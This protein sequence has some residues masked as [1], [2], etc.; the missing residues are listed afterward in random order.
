[1]IPDTFLDSLS[2]GNAFSYLLWLIVGVMTIVFLVAFASLLY[3]WHYYGIGFFKRWLL[4]VI[5][6]GVGAALVV[7]A[8][9]LMFKII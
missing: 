3:H 8:Y 1:M 6:G 2:L 4:I 5:F 9:G 7:S